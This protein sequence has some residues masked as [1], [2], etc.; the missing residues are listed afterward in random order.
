VKN[1]ALKLDT[2]YRI[3]MKLVIVLYLAFIPLLASGQNYF[4]GTIN[5]AHEV[6][7]KSKQVNVDRVEQI[8]G[9]GSTLFFKNGNFRHN[10]DGGI[11]EF[12]IYRKDNNRQYIKRRGIDTI[13]WYDCSKGGTPIKDLKTYNQKKKILGILCDQLNIKYADHSKVEYYNADS[14]ATD[15]GWFAAFKRDDQYKVDAIERSV[16][17]RSELDYPAFGFA[18][19]ATRIERKTISMDVFEIP[20]NAI[21]LKKE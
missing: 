16:F 2:K 21:L 18:S 19:Q 3:C 8:L 11:I 15:P 6:K 20:A 14:L 5:Y 7:P 4:E 13:Y 10:Y 17:L 12:G 9:K 1:V